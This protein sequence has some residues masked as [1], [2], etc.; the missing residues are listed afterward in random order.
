MGP[1]VGDVG[2]GVRGVERSSRVVVVTAGGE[3]GRCRVS[4]TRRA[5]R[6]SAADEYRW[7]GSLAIAV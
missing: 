6:I 4:R 7:S 3:D 5:F 1:E 2:V